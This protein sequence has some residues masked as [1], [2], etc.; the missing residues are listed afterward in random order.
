MYVGEFVKKENVFPLA[1]ATK[2]TIA[3]AELISSVERASVLIRG[4]KDNLIILDIKN[5]KVVINANSDIGKIEETVSAELEGKELKVAMNSK[6]LLDAVKALE[7]EQIILSFN[8]AVTP[9]T[10][11]NVEDK[12]SQYLVVPLRTSNT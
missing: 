4:E 12:S 1:F 9:F 7:E 11:E 3:R 2:V 10:L 6:Y 5:G 8:T